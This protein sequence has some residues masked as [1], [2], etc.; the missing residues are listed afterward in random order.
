MEEQSE[1]GDHQL[2]EKRSFVV[3]LPIQGEGGGFPECNKTCIKVMQEVGCIGF[4]LLAD[5]KKK[6]PPRST[7]SEGRLSL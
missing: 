5:W 2:R 4:Q 7:M 6:K 3:L 1:L